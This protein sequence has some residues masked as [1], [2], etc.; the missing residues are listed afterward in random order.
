[1]LVIHRRT[2]TY[3]DGYRR[4][5][6]SAFSRL[7][8][9]VFRREV[10]RDDAEEHVFLWKGGLVVP[11]GINP[12]NTDGRA[13]IFVVAVG[14]VLALKPFFLPDDISST[15]DVRPSWS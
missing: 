11:T 5:N 13:C 2:P 14:I 7:C 8:R 10:L 1:M 12:T 3:N 9:F 4:K 15:P 6:S